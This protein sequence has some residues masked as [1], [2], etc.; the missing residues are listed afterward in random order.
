MM[1]NSIE[2]RAR[3]GRARTPTANVP[4]GQILERDYK[5]L[6]GRFVHGMTLEES[7]RHAG[8]EGNISTLKVQAH[9]IINK[10][11]DANSELI[12]AMA[13][14]GINAESL[15]ED[16]RRGLQSTMFVKRKVSKDEEKLEEVPDFHARHKFVST[17]IDVVGANAPK[18]IEI[19]S[20]TFEQR[21][22]E[23]TLR[24]E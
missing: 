14:V 20:K 7:A 22:L 18:K 11:K 8:M 13:T 1:A 16:I 3:G 23:I 9:K 2:D 12:K 6:E 17:V 15:A 4:E 21:L 10:H 5:V 19:E 24:R